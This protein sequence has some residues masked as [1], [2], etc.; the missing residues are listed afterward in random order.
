MYEDGLRPSGTNRF[1]FNLIVRNLCW[2]S[3]LGATA[4]EW[5]LFVEDYSKCELTLR[6]DK[7]STLSYIVSAL[8]AATGDVCYAGL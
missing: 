3:T 5:H 1:D 4:Y 8:Q 6:R 2:N 7:L